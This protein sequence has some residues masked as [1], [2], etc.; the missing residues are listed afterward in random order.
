MYMASYMTSNDNDC[1]S[2]MRK[3]LFQVMNLYNK[4]NT[5]DADTEDEG[6]VLLDINLYLKREALLSSIGR[7]NSRVPGGRMLVHTHLVIEGCRMD[8][9]VGTVMVVHGRLMEGLLNVYFLDSV[10]NPMNLSL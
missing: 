10:F 9:S 7:F 8:Q 2:I 5:A 3:M 1:S 4:K 6:D